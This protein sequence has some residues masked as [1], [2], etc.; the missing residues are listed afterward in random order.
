[1][2]IFQASGF[3]RAEDTSLSV[4]KGTVVKDNLGNSYAIKNNGDFTVHDQSGK[5]IR[6][7]NLNNQADKEWLQKFAGRDIFKQIITWFEE[8]KAMQQKFLGQQTPKG[9][10]PAQSASVSEFRGTER[11]KRTAKDVEEAEKR[12]K[13]DFFKN[14]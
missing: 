3:G 6:E 9:V 1:M 4:G 10:S 13:D 8:I 11:A 12:G 14:S 7:G 2:F 5:L